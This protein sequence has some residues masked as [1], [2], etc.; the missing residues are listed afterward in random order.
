MRKKTGGARKGTF[1]KCG[2]KIPPKIENL[3]KNAINLLI[4]ENNLTRGS[5]QQLTG[6]RRLKQGTTKKQYNYYYAGLFSVKIDYS[7]FR[8]FNIQG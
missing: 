5:A 1:Y 4:Q 6:N 7:F 2:Y 8:N 3:A